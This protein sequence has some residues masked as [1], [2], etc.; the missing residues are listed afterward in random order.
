MTS[1]RLY[2][3]FHGIGNLMLIE[4]GRL[5]RPTIMPLISWTTPAARLP[6][7]PIFSAC[8]NSEK[9]QKSEISEGG[10]ENELEDQPRFRDG[11]GR[12]AHKFP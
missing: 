11:K 8:F 5:A 2:T 4:S 6:I 3:P 12:T 9:P 10:A 7:A 1:L